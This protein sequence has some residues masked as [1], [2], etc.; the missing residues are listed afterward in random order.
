[1]IQAMMILPLH[2]S[3]FILKVHEEDQHSFQRILFP[4]KYAYGDG[5]IT[6]LLYT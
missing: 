4:M 1:M 3:R 5:T 2:I 6:P